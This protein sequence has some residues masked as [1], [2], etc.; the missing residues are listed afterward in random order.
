[1]RPTTKD[2]AKAA[3]VS[4]ATVDRVL[5]RR[6][7]VRKETVDAVT[8]AIEEIGFER[9]ISA[10]NLARS[11]RYRFE[12]LLPTAGDQFLETLA[13]RIEEARI[14]FAAEHT[15]VRFRRVLSDDPHQIAAEL[16]RLGPDEVDGIAIMAPEAPQVRDATHR[17]YERGV[18]VVQFVAGQLG[19]PEVDF[20]GVDN[21][22]AGA[23]AGRLMG[24]FCGGRP[25]RVLVIAD[26]MNAR[27]NV[28]R[29]QGFDRI[30]T[31]DYPDLS[32]LP[33]LET[34]GDPARTRRIVANLFENFRDIAGVYVL[35]SETRVAL[36]AVSAVTDLRRTQVI[37][38]ERTAFNIAGL[39]S[40]E[41][42]A[43]IAQNPGHLVRSAI[44]VLRARCDGREP[45][46]S[47]EEI[48][49]EILIRENLGHEDPDHSVARD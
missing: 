35:S 49:I 21:N 45:I 12:F 7:G 34:H 44:R 14:A 3:G 4:L 9:N 23:T 28:E 13:S 24:K 5:N 22:A 32:A 27:D 37:A 41:L 15:E 17:L 20:V 40:G 25:G 33:S 47:Q 31:T 48:R 26:T 30:L 2:L 10:A 8:A 38:H 16:A 1:M 6:P 46:A 42:D 36:E 11:R 29:R 19:G 18:K 39:R 43:V